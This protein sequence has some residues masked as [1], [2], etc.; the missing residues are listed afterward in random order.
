MSLPSPLLDPSPP[1]C[2]KQLGP[3][4]LVYVR[5]HPTPFLPPFSPLPSL[6]LSFHPIL[7]IVKFKKLLI[8]WDILNFSYDFNNPHYINIE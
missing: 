5:P 8:R 4:L 3:P 1:Y 2:L 6:P 7:I